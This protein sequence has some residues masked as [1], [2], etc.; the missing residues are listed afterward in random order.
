VYVPQV[1]SRKAEQ[2]TI[3]I[4]REHMPADW[5]VHVCVH[6]WYHSSVRV[7]DSIDVSARSNLQIHCF[8]DSEYMARTILE[9]FPNAYIGF[10]GALTKSASL[11]AIVRDVIP[12]NRLLLETDGP[13]MV[14]AGCHGSVR[15]EG[16]VVASL[17]CS[18]IRWSD[19][20]LCARQVSHPGMC[21]V[22]AETIAELKG[23]S[24]DE[25]LVQ[26]RANTTAMYGI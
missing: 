19:W 3:D 14:P 15:T 16:A 20:Y 22:I 2:E 5:R 11:K 6:S 24:V 1:H 4:L 21:I 18:L 13:Y 23:L 8:N 17:G 9:T 7:F 26:I 12:L 10:T 25:V